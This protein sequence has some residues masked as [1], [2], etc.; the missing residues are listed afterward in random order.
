MICA[1]IG[2]GWIFL[3]NVNVNDVKSIN[4]V[5]LLSFGENLIN[6]FCQMLKLIS[7]ISKR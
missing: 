7:I 3:K 5:L 2:I 4:E 1:R 6:W